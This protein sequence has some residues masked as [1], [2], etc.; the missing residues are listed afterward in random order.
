MARNA[1]RFALEKR[2]DCANVSWYTDDVPNRAAAARSKMGAAERT[3]RSRLT[4]ILHSEGILRGNL[5]V[6]E[7]TCGKPNCRCMTG[8]E[9]HSAVYLVFSEGGKYQQVFVPKALHE[10]VR[11]W[12]ENHKKARDLLEEISQLH[13]SKLRNRE[14]SWEEY[15]KHK[16]VYDRNGNTYFNSEEYESGYYCYFPK[17]IFEKYCVR[18]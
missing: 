14:V 10:R 8:G 13:S 3:L 5:S 18:S 17:L 15:K 16:G 2:V 9:K 1:S 12:V 6:R 7:R 11:Q 4:R